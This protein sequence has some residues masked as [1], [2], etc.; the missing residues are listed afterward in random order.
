MGKAYPE[1]CVLRCDMR[2]KYRKL[3]APP[4]VVT[5]CHSSSY[6]YRIHKTSKLAI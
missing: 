5:S 3:G 6:Y 4:I 2:K 1:K